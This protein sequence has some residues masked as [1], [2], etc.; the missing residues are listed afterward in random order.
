MTTLIAVYNSEGCVG[1]CDAKCYA[2]VDPV[3]DC[4]CRGANHGKGLTVAMENTRELAHDWLEQYAE[5]KGLEI[6]K[7]IDG[8]APTR[9]SAVAFVN[10]QEEL[11]L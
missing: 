10:P 6:R 9:R 2:A 8:L 7:V 5:T 1:R 3:C 4:I 11:P